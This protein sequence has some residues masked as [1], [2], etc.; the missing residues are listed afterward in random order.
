[1]E[2]FGPLYCSVWFGGACVIAIHATSSAISS[3]Q[4]SSAQLSSAQLSSAQIS[5]A[6]LRSGLLTLVAQAS[7]VNFV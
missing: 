1:M 5:S 3:A 2:F 7:A 4:L 6:Q